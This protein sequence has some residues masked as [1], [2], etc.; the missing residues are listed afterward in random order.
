MEGVKVT[1]IMRTARST[2]RWLY[3]PVY[4]LMY[5]SYHAPSCSYAM[6]YQR[7]IGAGSSER[8]TI[9]G[10]VHVHAPLLRFT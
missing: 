7:F 3:L 2:L 9:G 8:P 6:A 4:G 10:L 5:C 1:W